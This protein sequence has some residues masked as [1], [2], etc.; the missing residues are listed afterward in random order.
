M[1][2]NI[3]LVI[4]GIVI[5]VLIMSLSWPKRIAKLADGKEVIVTV[6]DKTYSADDYYDL[7][8]GQ[9]NL[10][11]ILRK[12]NVDLTKA[13]YP[14]NETESVNYAND[15]YNTFLQQADAY[16]VTEEDALKQ[17]GYNSKE[18]MI[19]YL[20]DDYYLN[21]YYTEQLSNRFSDEDLKKKYD[22]YYFPTRKAYL[23]SSLDKA[24]LDN[25]KKQLDKGVSAN[26][27]ISDNSVAYNDLSY[28]FTDTAY[29]D[30]I[31]SAILMTG[32]N[33]TSNI[34]QDETYGYA[35]VYVYDIEESKSYEEVKD[36]LLEMSLSQLEETDKNINQ[37]I[38]IELQEKN[39]ISFKDT[40][41][42]DL[43]DKYKK[44]I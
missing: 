40:T 8:K 29:G 13:M 11:T 36:S 42:K 33:K 19:K 20:K 1:K 15:R 21:K 35:F 44:G 31:S 43:Y 27:I 17:Y 39:N 32:K 26:K 3:G 7:L 6:N 28:S 4:L 24:K 2:K 30:K 12:I 23:F 10:N 18:D 38:M 16:G 14:N 25:A 9:D 22:D 41:L 5:G 34:F 37:K